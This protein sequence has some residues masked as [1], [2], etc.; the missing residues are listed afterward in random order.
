MSP[1]LCIL[2]LCSQCYKLY[3]TEVDHDTAEYQCQC[4]GGY[5]LAKIPSAEVNTF[6]NSL[7]GGVDAWIGL[8]DKT[9]EGTYVWSDSSALG[10][11]TNWDTSQPNPANSANQDCVRIEGGNNGKWDDILC[12]KSYKFVCESAVPSS[13]ST[14]ASTCTTVTTAGTTTVTTGTAPTS[15]KCESGW[16]HYAAKNKCVKLFTDTV[17]SLSIY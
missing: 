12:S 14:P 16:W 6:V 13:L 15:E 11:Y 2:I 3:T 17:I 8:N 5:S 7:L 10:T 4:T 9:T 1:S